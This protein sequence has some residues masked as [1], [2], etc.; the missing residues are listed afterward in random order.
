MTTVILHIISTAIVLS[1]YKWYNDR[2]SW[3]N[4]IRRKTQ[5]NLKDVETLCREA[6]N[7]GYDRCY[8]NVSEYTVRGNY[9]LDENGWIIN[10]LPE[11]QSK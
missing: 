6:Y 2:Y 3:R 8:Y 1:A 10:N 4:K 5:Y 11:Q 9:P 7:E